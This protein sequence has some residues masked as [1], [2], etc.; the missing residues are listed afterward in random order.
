[1]HV[2][3]IVSTQDRTAD[4]VITP[5]SSFFPPDKTHF[6][7]HFLRKTSEWCHLFAA[8]HLLRHLGT[9]RNFC[10]ELGNFT[11]NVFISSHQRAQTPFSSF[12]GHSWGAWVGHGGLGLAR[13][14][15]EPEPALSVVCCMNHAADKV[16]R[17]SPTKL[18]LGADL[19]KAGPVS[20]R[21]QLSSSTGGRREAALA[22]N[23]GEAFPAQRS[24]EIYIL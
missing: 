4:C 23:A 16:Y 10:H 2:L 3:A 9:E 7:D 11:I 12:P 14:F 5:L 18:A 13:C 1:M 8:A 6:A 21:Q 20:L 19:I 17:T 15:P 24:Q 22:L